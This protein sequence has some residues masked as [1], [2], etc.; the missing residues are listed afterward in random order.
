MEPL[1]KS[2]DAVC[3]S[4]V[5]YTPVLQNIFFAVLHLVTSHRFRV[6]I[7][8]TVMEFLRN[9][10]RILTATIHDKTAWL[11][12]RTANAP[13]SA[14][15]GETICNCSLWH[16]RLGHIGKD[17]LEKVIKGKLAS[18]LHLNSN[19]PLLVHCEPCIIG[20]H[21]ANPFPAKASHRAMHMLK[22]V[23]SNLHMA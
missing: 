4:R 21:H 22:H 12:V 17:L 8:G 6:V 13:E 18:G 15:R 16:R 14:L 1:D 3:L 5:L 10:M 2:L 23:H 19:A 11:N 9:G 20:K 7:E